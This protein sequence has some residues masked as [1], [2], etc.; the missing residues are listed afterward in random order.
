MHLVIFRIG[1]RISSAMTLAICPQWSRLLR[2]GRRVPRFA[3]DV[4]VALVAGGLF[5]GA[6]VACI[7]A[8]ARELNQLAKSGTILIDSEG[9]ILEEYQANLQPAGGNGLHNLFLK[10]V[11]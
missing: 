6:P 9:K 10:H 8:C 3:V 5:P 11:L 7:G 2:R 4:N 1:P